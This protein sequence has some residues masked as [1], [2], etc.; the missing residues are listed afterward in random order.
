M[1]ISISLFTEN[2][3]MQTVQTVIPTDFYKWNAKIDKYIKQ[4]INKILI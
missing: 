2:N 4:H 1:I 3:Y